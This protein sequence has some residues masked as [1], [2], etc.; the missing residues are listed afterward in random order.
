MEDEA[1]CVKKTG[2][3]FCVQLF[4]NYLLLCFPLKAQKTP[5]PIFT[6]Q[7]SVPIETCHAEVSWFRIPVFNWLL[8]EP[9]PCQLYKRTYTGIYIP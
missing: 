6:M 4:P 8:Y 9:T 3:L 2:Y 1:N 7:K 5:P